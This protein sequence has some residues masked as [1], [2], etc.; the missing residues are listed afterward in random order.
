MPV[1]YTP[2]VVEAPANADT[3]ND[4]F[5]EL[6]QAIVNLAGG[7][8]VPADTLL[9]WALAEAYYLSEA[10]TYHGTYTDTIATVDIVWP[11]G[12]TGTYTAVTI[13]P[14][15]EEPTEFTLTHTASSQTV[16][17]EGLVRDSAGRITTPYSWSVA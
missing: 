6:D 5:E 12:E 2:I 11:D 14:V 10:P 8:D 7:A 17:A 16:T 4:V 3:F 15:W 9:E 1:H 13:D